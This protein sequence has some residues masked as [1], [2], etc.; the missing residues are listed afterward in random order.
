MTVRL[1]PPLE[2]PFVFFIRIGTQ[3]ATSR[4]TV[5]VTLV[6]N[7]L[8][9]GAVVYIHTLHRTVLSRRK[10]EEDTLHRTAESDNQIHI[11]RLLVL[12]CHL[13]GTQGGGGYFTSHR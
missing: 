6:E 11:L 4:S 1:V 8:I 9:R 13:V 2:P 10:E 7:T 12:K 5:M 3:K